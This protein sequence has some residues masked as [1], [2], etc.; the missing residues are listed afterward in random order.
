MSQ[1]RRHPE[2]SARLTT[3][4]NVKRR[5]VL[6]QSPPRVRAR[7]HTVL[8]DRRYLAQLC[9][10]R[11]LEVMADQPGPGAIELLPLGHLVRKLGLGRPIQI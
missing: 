10:S 5:V 7:D 3:Q 1:H 11:H 4:M 8:L 9:S 2:T 6:G